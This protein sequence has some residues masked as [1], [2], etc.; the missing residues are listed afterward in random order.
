MGSGVLDKACCVIA[1]M[2]SYLMVVRP[3]TAG[4]AGIQLGS[5]LL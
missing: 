1:S 5:P 3:Y 4:F 2:K